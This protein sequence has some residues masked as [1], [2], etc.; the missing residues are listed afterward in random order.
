MNLDVVFPNITSTLQITGC[1]FG[2]KPSGW[3]YPKHHHHLYEVFHCREGEVCVSLGRDALVLR[4]GDWLL[5]RA[6]VRHAID[7]RTNGEV[8]FFNIHFDL[9]DH[10][11]R[12]RLGGA[13]YTVIPSPDAAAADLPAYLAEIEALMSEQLRRSPVDPAGTERRLPLASGQRI[14]LQAYILLIVNEMIRRQ[15]ESGRGARSEGAKDPTFYEADMAHR[16]EER[17][18]RLVSS[19]GS[20][21]QIAEALNVS[22]SQCTKIFTKIYGIPPRQYVTQLKL[23]KAKELLVGTNR[24]VED[25]ANELGFHSASHFSRQFRRGTGMSPNQFRPRH[26]T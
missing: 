4:P 12:K 16:I 6:G 7:N 10:D 1:H 9:D 23:S 19:D 11:L 2:F 8:A 5:L 20:I 26:M 22:R 25:I 13:D 3:S 14:V 15:G 21:S 18:E 24:T 17:L